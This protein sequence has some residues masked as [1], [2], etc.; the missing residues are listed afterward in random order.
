[1]SRRCGATE[2]GG[3]GAPAVPAAAAP[4]PKR[5][6]LGGGVAPLVDAAGGELAAPAVAAW[7]PPRFLEPPAPRGNVEGASRF[8]ILSVAGPDLPREVYYLMDEGLLVEASLDGVRPTSTAGGRPPLVTILMEC[9][10]AEAF[11]RGDH[12]PGVIGVAFNTRELI[13]NSVRLRLASN[14]VIFTPMVIPWR[15]QVRVIRGPQPVSH[16]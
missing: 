15:L 5:Q 11:R 10:P 9:D 12:P 7:P 3:A 4:A 8:R 16:P 14:G 2:A 1:M 6:P 13:R